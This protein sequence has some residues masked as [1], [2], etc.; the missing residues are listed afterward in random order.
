MT[1]AEAPRIKRLLEDLAHGDVA[2][3]FVA[4]NDLGQLGDPGA[5]PKLSEAGLGHESRAI[6]GCLA[7]A[8]A[9][10]GHVDGIPAIKTLLG[11]REKYVQDEAVKALKAVAGKMKGQNLQQNPHAL[12]L[13]RI[14][15][16]LSSKSA[17]ELKY[18]LEKELGEIQ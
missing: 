7:M 10:I 8:L 2:K 1:P 11:D 17:G 9:N 15:P 13:A 4:I 14:A 5:I 3:K 16:H 12:A 18:L 6:R